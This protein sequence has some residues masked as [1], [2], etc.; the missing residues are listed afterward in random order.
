[1]SRRDLLL[2]VLSLH[3]HLSLLFHQ[4]SYSLLALLSLSLR[5]QLACYAQALAD[6]GVLTRFDSNALARPFDL[7]QRVDLFCLQR[8]HLLLCRRA[9]ALCCGSCC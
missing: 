2:G 3:C 4:L 6:V 1:M 8:V 5:V 9:R 7:V